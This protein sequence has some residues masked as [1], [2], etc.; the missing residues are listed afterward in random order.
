MTRKKSHAHEST[1]TSARSWTNT[2]KDTPGN[3]IRSACFAEALH[4]H[5]KRT[6]SKG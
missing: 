2:R 6:K 4:R 3:R 5:K 1:E